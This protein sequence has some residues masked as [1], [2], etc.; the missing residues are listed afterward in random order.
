MRHI[1]RNHFKL[2]FCTLSGLPGDLDSD[3]QALGGQIHS[4]RLTPDFPW[5][6]RRL[7]R[8]NQYDVVHSHIHYSSGLI[9]RLA[10][11]ADVPKR[12]THFRV[13]D[14]G[15]SRQLG[16]RLQR[17]WMRQWIQQYS[18]HILAVS[19]A[20]MNAVWP[21][22]SADSRCQV[23]Y[24]G[25]DTWPFTRPV[26]RESV[27]R[28]LGLPVDCKVIIHVGRLD[29]QKNHQRLLFMF[30]DILDREPTA[31]LLLV[32][33]GG[34]SEP[35]V[36]RVVVDLGLTSYVVFAGLRTDVP[37]LLQ[38]A[39]LFLFPSLREGLPGAVLE[40]CA[41]GLP[42]LAS[43]TA[44]VQEIAEYF[45]HIRTASLVEPD[46]AW[47]GEVIKL[48]SVERCAIDFDST[49]FSLESAA[50]KLCDIW[51]RKAEA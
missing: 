48:L 9:M 32:G 34:E 41:T 6:F 30:R 49:P 38:S 16:P 12:I 47:A 24:N 22:W 10:A 28:G 3:I 21:H 23:V 7:L 31:R 37:E 17:I 2:D 14:D 44:G 11:Q 18:T 42:V 5:R 1:D 35:L 40:A 29:P 4:L 33:R 15:K 8:D 46:S 27:R 50:R 26:N 25:L 51:S 36:R 20:T 13:A 19:Y 45:P 43:T 39:D